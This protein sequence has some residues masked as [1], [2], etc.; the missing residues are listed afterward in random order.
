MQVPDGLVVS[1]NGGD[2][3]A[4]VVRGLSCCGLLRV[5]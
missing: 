3:R 2:I 1:L 4:V 5:A